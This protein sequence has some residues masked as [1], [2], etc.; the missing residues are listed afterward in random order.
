MLLTAGSVTEQARQSGEGA[1]PPAARSSQVRKS[2]IT[3]PHSLVRGDVPNENKVDL[4]H[5]Q[6]STTQNSQEG[7]S[8]PENRI[9]SEIRCQITTLYVPSGKSHNRVESFK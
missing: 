9:S 5:T 7:K 4:R 1:R 2:E 3:S 8:F 6:K